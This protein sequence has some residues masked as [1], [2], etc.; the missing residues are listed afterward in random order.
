MPG[1]RDRSS[2]QL[3][4]GES[5]GANILKDSLKIPQKSENRSIIWASLSPKE[6]KSAH[7]WV[8]STP[9]SATAQ[10]WTQSRR[11]PTDTCKGMES[12]PSQW[13][14]CNWIRLCLVD[15]KSPKNTQMCKNN[16]N[17]LRVESQSQ[18]RS[19]FTLT[20]VATSQIWQHKKKV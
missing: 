8:L 18:P 2:N 11:P 13:N 5:M 4:V 9:V 15:C 14:G 16:T 3:L 6:R 1:V 20:R 12:C 7:E 10:I 17:T 19:Y